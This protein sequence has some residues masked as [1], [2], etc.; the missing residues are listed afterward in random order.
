LEAD[1]GLLLDPAVVARR[2]DQARPVSRYPSSDIDLAFVV[3][4][5]L[6][7][8]D[9]LETLRAAPA[10]LARSDGPRGDAST[11]DIV[12]DIALFDVYRSGSLG[13]GNRGLT[14]RVR[15]RAPDRT[16]RDDEIGAL[17]AWMI[18]EAEQLGAALRS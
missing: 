2:S 8:G 1:L 12:E 16:L 10:I 5:Q 11:V 17:R 14:F 15:L 18:D 4:A 13:E 6:S 7:A 9:L 3:P